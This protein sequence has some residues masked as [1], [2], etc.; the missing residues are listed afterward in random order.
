MEANVIEQLSDRLGQNV[1]QLRQARGKTQQQ[2]ASLAGVPR[3]TWANLE[4][5]GANP[6]LAVLHAVAVALG[7]SLEELLGPPRS[8]ARLWPKEALP[9]RQR[10]H[11]RIR[12]LLPD[13]VPGMEIRALRAPARSAH[14]RN[15]T[16]GWYARVP[17]LRARTD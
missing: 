6:T 8:A 9:T 12:R 10:G 3:A 5:G 14:D 11:V 17:R 7:V 15:A 1:R 13:P 2:M 4:T 16:H